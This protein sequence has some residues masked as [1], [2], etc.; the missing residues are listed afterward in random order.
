[1]IL[2]QAILQERNGLFS[3]LLRR[4]KR[5]TEIATVKDVKKRSVKREKPL[6]R[7]SKESTLV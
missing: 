6:N 1:V 4:A 7:L 2:K 5:I 3:G